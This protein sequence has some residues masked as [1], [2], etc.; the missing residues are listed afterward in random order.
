MKRLLISHIADEDGITPVI[1]AKLVYKNIDILLLNPKEVDSAVLENIDNYDSIHIVDLNVSSA[2]AQ[3]I[4][5]NQNWKKKIKVFDH[6]K[7]ELALNK[8][9][10][11]TVIDD[12]ENQKESGT[13]IYYKYLLS[14]SDNEVLHKQVTKQFV[15]QVRLVDTYDFKTKEDEKSKDL[16][17]IFA[18][19]GYEKYIT[20]FDNYIK[21][22]DTFSYGSN[23]ELL[24]SL[25]KDKVKKYVSDKEKEMFI[26]NLDNHLAGLV[27][28]ENYRTQV[29]NML[30][31]MHPELDFMV[32]VNVSRSI[33]YRAN[34]KADL[35][36]I[37]NKY[38][39][40]G[41]KN[42][43]G[44]PLPENLKETIAKIIF[45]DIKFENKNLTNYKKSL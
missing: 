30:L 5:E 39:G 36:V 23:E 44:S 32:V 42:S 13:S 8:Y 38:N 40:G 45:P 6:H 20:Y 22:N 3:K 18:I 43:G 37:T 11:I 26:V 19:L 16:D 15:N 25:E 10:F 34:G 24:I 35:T 12:G 27:F 33:S 7:S 41:H 29:G 4:D 21:N 2:F 1:L 17:Y 31:Q 9:E 28:A 14:I